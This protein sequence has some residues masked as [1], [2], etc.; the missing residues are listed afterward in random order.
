VSDQEVQTNFECGF[1]LKGQAQGGISVRVVV[2]TDEPYEQGIATVQGNGTWELLI[3]LGGRCDHRLNHIV[4]AELLDAE[5]R[6][7]ATYQVENVKR[8]VECKTPLELL[9]TVCKVD[10]QYQGENVIYLRE[11]DYQ[12]FVNPASLMVTVQNYGPGSGTISSVAIGNLADTT[13]Y[14]R[15]QCILSMRYQLRQQLGIDE[16]EMNITPVAAR[17]T[18]QVSLTPLQQ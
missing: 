14:T 13:M 17:P 18:H 5:E 9:A 15:T 10:A 11:E 1:V 12:C 4:T 6:V 8:T 7:V 2:Y 3:Y 16:S